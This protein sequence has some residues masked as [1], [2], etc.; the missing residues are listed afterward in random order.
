MISRHLLPGIRP[1]PLASYLAG[2]GLIRL[3]GEQA[4]PDV[5][6]AW[7]ADGLVI[8]TR[9]PDLAEWLT[10]SYV[11]TPVVSPWNGG[12]GFGAKD[13][14]PLRVLNR[15][16]DHPSPRL[17]GFRDAI[18]I[19]KQVV[20]ECGDSE[21]KDLVLQFRNRCPEELL[22]WID[23]TVVLT[24][25]DPVFPPLLGT[26]G[27][28]GR[29]DFSTNFHQRLLEV[30]GTPPSLALA[31]DLLCGTETEK[32]ASAA[33]GQFD[34]AGAGGPGSSRFG[35]AASLVNPWLFVLFVEGALMFASSTVR[36]NQFEA[37]RAAIP[38]T[39]L[40]SPAGSASGAADEE[41]RGEVWAP[42][43]D[44]DFTL[45]EIRQLFTE[46]RAS[47]RGR[48]ARRAV[49]FYA[50]T[51][52]VGVA[53]G[54]TAFTRFGLQRRNGLAFVAVPLARVEVI[55]RP[56]VRLVADVEDW[57]NRFAGDMPA[58]IKESSRAFQNAHWEYVK[59]G[60]PREL[61]AMLASL[62]SLEQTVARSGRARDNVKVRWLPRAKPFLPELVKAE[63]R[64]LR[65]AIG[66]ASCSASR[67]TLRQLLLPIDP[68]GHNGAWRDS[69]VISG[70]GARP[71]YDILAD[72]LVWR[73]RTA[74]NEPGAANFRGV[75]TF[76]WG[77]RVPADD[78]YWLASADPSEWRN[79]EVQLRACLAL[80]W[81]G[82]QHEWSAPEPAM[83][84]AT[85]GLLLPLAG[86]IAA[87]D[88]RKLAMNPDWATRL[89]AGQVS[90]VHEQARARLR[91]VGWNAVPAAPIELSGP[92]IAAALVTRC[93][94]PADQV[95]STFAAK[96]NS[97]KE[98]S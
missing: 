71:L 77:V 31:K 9:T 66:L 96:S 29:L 74:V 40:P 39:V 27:N 65:I 56:Q 75:P 10:E 23:A 12:S 64:T 70:F 80:D 87:D 49:Q 13:K 55:E 60:G 3:L 90:Q 48:P 94:E 46:A 78:L 44:S 7:S 50:A 83:P 18:E 91:Q 30:I 37:G 8:A 88:G 38:F 73:S 92:R 41:S 59:A 47:W 22:P 54:V 82:I 67:R 58:S 53:R 2:L 63:S 1:E 42:L 85:L 95:L 68:D 16:R 26:G 45:P 25:G 93:Q 21:K 97:L 89:K 34:P 4:D 20:E 6:A 76:Q 84:V 11:P 98:T 35:P 86:G 43:W 72:V 19:A 5:S 61:V 14:E 24:G 15:L 69:P 33:I 81:R 32:L 79:L 62:T 57:A 17:D 28:D 52:T 51:R 36:R